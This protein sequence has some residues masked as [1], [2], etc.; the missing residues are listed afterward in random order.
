MRI[1]ERPKAAAAVPSVTLTG[2]GRVDAT[3]ATVSEPA[4]SRQ[5]AALLRGA[6]ARGV[7]ARGLGRSYN[8]AAQNDGGSVIVMTATEPRHEAS[9]EDARRRRLRGGRQPRAAHADRAARWLVRPGVAGDPAGDHR[10]RDRGGCARQEP[11]PGGQLRPARVRGS[12]CY[13]PA[14][15]S[16][17]VTPQRATPSCSGRRRAGWA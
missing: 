4:D 8:N 17:R 15:G 7:I 9:T 14:A 6:P 16:Q 13:C 5:V 2:W 3:V 10:R 12:T 11:S 1:G